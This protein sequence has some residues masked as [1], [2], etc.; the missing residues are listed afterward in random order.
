MGGA[1][2]KPRSRESERRRGGEAAGKRA[3]PPLAPLALSPSGGGAPLSSELRRGE[4]GPRVAL[5]AVRALDRTRG[6]LGSSRLV[7]AG[8]WEEEEGEEDGLPRAPPAPA[9]SHLPS[10]P[11]SP[12]RR[13][14]G[15]FIPS[16]ALYKYL[17]SAHGVPSAGPDAAGMRREE[18]EPALASDAESGLGRGLSGTGGILV[19]PRGKTLGQCGGRAAIGEG[20][21]EEVTPS[22]SRPSAPPPTSPRTLVPLPL[23][24]PPPQHLPLTFALA[25]PSARNSLPSLSSLPLC[26]APTA[27]G[28]PST[29]GSHSRATSSQTWRD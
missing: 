27:A 20:F 5:P 13:P 17:P 26:L 21:P 29:S 7:R 14:M 3:L 11:P 19:G 23:Q 24:H 9:A 18:P 15:S 6:R 4:R 10:A 1:A 16:S 12:Q 25:I 22:P 8:A 28:R 2:S